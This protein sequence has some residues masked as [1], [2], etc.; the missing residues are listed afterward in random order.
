MDK[1]INFQNYLYLAENDWDFLDKLIR[2]SVLGLKELKYNYQE[3]VATQNA[4]QLRDAIHKIKPTLIV[5]EAS[6]L[7][8]YLEASKEILDEVSLSLE[9]ALNQAALVS[10]TVEEIIEI[11]ENYIKT[12][13]SVQ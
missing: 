5:L 13:L 10:Q 7:L 12:N 3:A 8:S 9:K 6:T 4:A 2:Q 1:H 11:M